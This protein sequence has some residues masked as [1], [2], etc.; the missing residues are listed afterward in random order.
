MRD[1]EDA[2]RAVRELEEVAERAKIFV[3]MPVIRG[4]TPRILLD[5]DRSEEVPSGEPFTRRQGVFAADEIG[6]A[7][8]DHS[9]LYGDAC[10][11]GILIHKR[12]I[13]LYREHME[14]WWRSA[15][16]L[17]ID[18]PYSLEDLG[19]IIWETARQVGFGTEEK[20]YLRPVLTR[21]IGDLGINPRKCSGATVFTIASTIKLY[22]E[23]KYQSGIGLGLSRQVRRAGPHVLD[24]SVKSNN[25]LNNVLGLIEGT[26]GTG[27]MES[28]MLT[29]DGFIAEATVDNI[30]L[31]KRNEGWEKDPSR[32]TILT[33]VATYCLGGI[34]RASI[35][36][37]AREEGYQVEE[38]PYMLPIDLTGSECECFMTG[39]GA[40]I[41]PVVEVIG[42]KVGDGKPG[43]VTRRL[44][45]RILE[46]MESPEWGIS[47]DA[48]EED[49]RSYLTGSGVKEAMK[50]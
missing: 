12:N 19:V 7:C 10:F 36:K 28:L 50:A 9:I 46:A 14:R 29:E 13:F 49:V 47:L 6:L 34:T 33:P 25:Y 40:G 30:F 15:N 39:T 18:F 16:K 11:E 44:R 43:P 1:P 20:G 3:S 42:R 21:G 38:T 32:V 23:E 31:V 41:M 5:D 26:S 24:P 2:R 37:L 48:R 22:P 27:F 35:M 45:E 4:I 8:F 17:S